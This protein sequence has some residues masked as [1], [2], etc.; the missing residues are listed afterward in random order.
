MEK[1][2]ILF[3]F[4]GCSLVPKKISNTNDP[5]I[6]P[7]WVYSPYDLC[8]QTNEIC[9]T[10]EGKSFADADSEAR[11][12]LA[13]I[14][15][16]KVS[17]NLHS[18]DHS[19]QNQA[20]HSSVQQEVHKVLTE[21]VQQ[22]LETVE[23]KNRFK[24]QGIVYSIASLDRMKAGELLAGRLALIDSELEALWK[25]RQRTS[26]RKITALTLER[27]KLHERYSLIKQSDLAPPVSYK[28]VLQWRDSQSFS[29]PLILRIGHAPEWLIDK[30]HELLTESGFRIVKSDAKKVV[31]ID[32]TSIKEYLNVPGFEKYTF[33]MSLTSTVNGVKLKEISATETVN[34][35]NQT[36]ALIKVKSFFHDY[37]EKNL[38]QLN[39]D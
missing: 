3:I 39:L 33:S 12:N 31:E 29:E 14:F 7:A 25:K 15:E 4:W 1:I 16:V 37:L 32:V 24:S 10:G 35:R 36:D 34:G 5:S 22:I 26:L 6:L 9:A 13:S 28:E 18:T 20:W 30:V 2:L 8:V 19:Y 38:S 21:S 11:V 27:E 17:S 23:I